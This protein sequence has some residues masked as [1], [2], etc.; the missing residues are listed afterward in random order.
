MF[1][2]C[3]VPAYIYR[4]HKVVQEVYREDTIVLGDNVFCSNI[5]GK[6][7]YMRQLSLDVNE[8]SLF[9]VF[10]SS[11]SRLNLNLEFEKDYQNR[12]DST[13]RFDRKAVFEDEALAHVL[14]LEGDKGKLRLIPVI[15]YSHSYKSGT[16]ISGSGVMDDLGYAK[17]I[18]LTLS[19]VIAKD[20]TILYRST[21]ITIGEKHRSYDPLEIKHNLTTEDW[22]K[23]VALAM[24]DYITRIQPQ[25]TTPD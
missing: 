24:N 11:L 19:I 8:D 10:Q 14:S 22:D 15:H 20:N 18:I 9:Q 6:W 21:A 12:C 4:R 25:P 23:L 17:Q 1:A 7:G 13:F 16:Y 3:A 2:S 5:M